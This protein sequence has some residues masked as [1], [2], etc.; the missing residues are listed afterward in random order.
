[1]K[2]LKIAPT[3]FFADYGC[4]VRILEEIRILQQM[5]HS[6]VLCTYP[7]GDSPEGLDIRRATSL[8]NPGVKVGPARRKY[9]LDSLLLMRSMQVAIKFRPNI[10]HAHLHDGAAIG[11]V[12]SRLMRVPLVFDY[13]GS[14]TGEMVDHGFLK[15]RSPLFPLFSTIERIV[16]RMP[17]AIITS[18]ANSAAALSKKR[19]NVYAVPDCV[20]TDVFKRMDVSRLRDN[21]PKGRMVVYLGLLQEYQGISHLLRA[22]REV[23]AH[24]LIMG[25]PG[26]EK[27]Q[28]MADDLGI[29]S[30]V[31]FTGRIPYQDAPLYLSL[32]DVAV[33]PKLS[34]T[35]G[36]GKLLNYMAMGLP[37]V[38]F[39]TP[40]SR[41]ILGDLG[42]YARTGDYHDLA[43]KIESAFT[44]PVGP[45]LR[46]R[47]I[48][49]YSWQQ[50]GHLIQKVYA[51][52]R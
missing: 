44:S 32:G 12:V 47:A 23:D 31:T 3:F 48:R 27:Y 1:V 50:G 21:F 17:D 20:N 33:S 16:D 49:V 7:S 26:L 6:V 38:T 29:S 22:A 25:F 37:T 5:G 14:L 18:T 39:D 2:I 8:W 24:F 9:Y 13:Q 51:S 19:G 52:L 43:A 35:E 36:N 11:Y 40:V 42:I 4:H 30:K 28:N 10:V 34:E 45:A 46:E 15:K 41:E